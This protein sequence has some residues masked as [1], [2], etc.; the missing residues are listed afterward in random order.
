MFSNWANLALNGRF[1]E[2]QYWNIIQASKL[3]LYGQKIKFYHG[4]PMKETGFPSVQ[5]KFWSFKRVFRN[6]RVWNWIYLNFRIVHKNNHIWFLLV[7]I[8]SPYVKKFSVCLEV[9]SESTTFLL[10]WWFGAA[11]IWIS[12]GHLFS[13]VTQSCL[14]EMRIIVYNFLLLIEITN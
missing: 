12:F 14:I 10:T 13:K 2:P 9:P 1:K 8:I 5:K 7:L 11:T 6:Q 4:S 3:S